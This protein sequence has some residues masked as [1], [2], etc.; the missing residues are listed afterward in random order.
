MSPSHTAEQAVHR[1]VRAWWVDALFLGVATLLAELALHESVVLTPAPIPDNIRGLVDAVGLV[2]IVS[3]LFA[4]TLYRRSVDAKYARVHTRQ[5]KAPGSPHHRVRVAVLGSLSVFAIIVAV[6]LWGNVAASRTLAHQGEIIDVLSRLR[7]HGERIGRFSGSQ[8]NNAIDDALMVDEIQRLAV[9][10]ASLE[11]IV[12]SEAY[13]KSPRV[14]AM[15][16][17]I[18]RMMVAERSLQATVTAHASDTDTD[19]ETEKARRALEIFQRADE[20][21]SLASMAVGAAQRMQNADI[22]QAERAAWSGG[23][24]AFAVLIGIALLVVEPVVRLLRRQHVTVTSK[25]LEFERLA[26]VAQRTSNAVVLTDAKRRITWANEG[27]TRLTGWE[28]QEVV[29]QSPGSVLQAPDTDPEAIARMRRAM[30]A[31]ESVRVTLLNRTK[32]GKPYWLDLSIEPLRVGDELTG[33]VAVESDVTEQVQASE[34]LQREREA[35]AKTM[36]Q[37]QEAQA[38]ARVGNWEFDF[39]HG[40]VTWSSETYSL[41]GLDMDR[42]QPDMAAVLDGYHP[43]DAA[44]LTAAVERAAT[45][46]EAYSLVLRTS[47][48]NPMVRWVR[49]EGRA[50]RGPD[51]NI[52]GLFGT[53][54]DVTEA[55]EREDALRQAQAKA[56]AASRSKSEFL[57]NMSHEIRTPLTAILGYTDLLRDEAA[58]GGAAPE[59]LQAMDTIRRAGE[60]LLTVINDILDI[61][62]IEAGKMEIEQVNTALPSVLLDVESLMRSRAQAKGISLEN[63]IA[64]PIPDRIVTDPTRLRQILMNLVGNAAKFTERGRILVETSVEQQRT[65]DMLVIAVDDTG[66]GMT[67]E[68]ASQLFQ[69]FTQADSSVT[70]KHGGTGLG[71]TICRRLAELMGGNV[72]LVTTAPGRGSRFELRLPLTTAANARSISH[73]EYAVAS[74][75]A[76][77]PTPRALSGRRILLAEDGEDNQRLITVLLQA[78]GAD[79]TVV[80]NG[81]QALEAIEWAEAAGARFDLLLS[82]MQMPEVDGYTLAAVLRANDNPIPIIALTAHAM[83]EDRQKCLDAGCDDYATKPIDRQALIA[84]CARWVTP[85]DLFQAMGIAEPVSMPESFVEDIP[86]LLV[87]ELA[88]DPDLAA[89]ATGFAEVLPDRVQSIASLVQHGDAEGAARLTHQLKGAAGG[90]GYPIISEL[91]R[92]LETSLSNQMHETPRLLARLSVYAAAAR[93]AVLSSVRAQP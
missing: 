70:R 60:H 72:E 41:F 19:S 11:K 88:D 71:L 27:F 58:V 38:V 20:F 42:G 18:T 62:K 8:G 73:L 77:A 55:I 54:M 87:S 35:L 5:L 30:D 51:K 78:A 17:A 85:P 53:V 22:Q 1:R 31:G 93:R 24:L 79:V 90:Y 74:T 83:A 7:L 80:A 67:E 40:Q 26:M 3:P 44:R 75:P 56:E 45:T 16:S 46:G 32:Q 59:Q 86:E 52:L 14:A 48:R 47:G 50:R 66:P 29:G 4:W 12:L 61:S 15:D 82:D 91:A 81:R 2:F 63:R 21:Q 65:N 43:D 13:T 28:L 33:F 9:D 10:V 23:F 34:A 39:Q 57:A 68:Q 49:G 25:S 6:A 84:T 37:L 76:A 89:L 92:Q 69:P 64:T 36:A